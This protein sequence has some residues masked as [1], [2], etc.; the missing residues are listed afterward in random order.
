RVKT[1]TRCGETKPL[2]HFPPIKRSEPERLQWWCRACFSDANKQ[3]YWKNHEREKARLL[4]QTT[5]KREENRHRAIEYLSAHPCID[6]GE[7]DIVVL[8][9]DHLRDKKFNVSTMIANGS[10]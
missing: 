2:D 8:Q 6:C 10:S 3:N 5:R 7:K 1:C 9:F 4:A